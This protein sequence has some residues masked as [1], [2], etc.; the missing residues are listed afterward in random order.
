[1]Q[2]TVENHIGQQLILDK[3]FPV[4]NA[5]G[6]TPSSATINTFGAGIA[7][8]T[9]YNSSYVNSRNIVLTIVPEGNAEK[10]RLTLYRYFKPKY[11]VRL[12]FKT[13]F[14][15]VYIDG[16]IETF[17]GALYSQKQAFQ[18]SIICPQPFFID[19]E[20]TVV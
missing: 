4:I 3:N 10:A 17:E 12:Y 2:I 19:I 9:F 8:G 18:I 16:Y 1:M 6:L 13:A 15:N 14:R 5:E 20:Q 7:D 11:K